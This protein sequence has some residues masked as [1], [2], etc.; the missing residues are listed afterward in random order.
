MRQ[1][2]KGS[3]RTNRTI[4]SSAISDLDKRAFVNCS[5]VL[6]SSNKEAYTFRYFLE[7]IF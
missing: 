6:T 3:E 5:T 2:Q 1:L 4:S 7:T